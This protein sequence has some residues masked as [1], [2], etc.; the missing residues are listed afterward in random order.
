MPIEVVCLRRPFSPTKVRLPEEDG[1][2]AGALELYS[3]SP[4]S[5]HECG[6]PVDVKSATL[7]ANSIGLEVWNIGVSLN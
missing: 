1:F 2:P 3:G 4:F 6:E 5:I 7:R